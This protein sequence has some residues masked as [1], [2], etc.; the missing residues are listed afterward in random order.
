MFASPTGCWGRA[1]RME[2]P[3]TDR[4]TA[5][6][7]FITAASASCASPADQSPRNIL[8]G[9]GIADLDFSMF[10]EFKSTERRGRKPKIQFGPRF[11]F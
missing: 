5:D 2:D 4:G 6:H 7:C 3:F 8:R 11:T 1:K 9:S 10:R